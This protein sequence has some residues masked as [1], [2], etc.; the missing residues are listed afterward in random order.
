MTA[1]LSP[2]RRCPPQ[3]PT[4]PQHS[5]PVTQPVSKATVPAAA[6]LLNDYG[7]IACSGPIRRTSSFGCWRCPELL[8]WISKRL[9]RRA[10]T[11]ICEMNLQLMWLRGSC[12]APFTIRCVTTAGWWRT[13]RP[14]PTKGGGGQSLRAPPPGVRRP[15]CRATRHARPAPGPRRRPARAPPGPAP[16]APPPRR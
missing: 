8:G 12:R 10:M 2:R 4:P 14:P 13:S 9:S 16:Y 3:L 15:P 6:T 1:K 7:R 11:P 5:F